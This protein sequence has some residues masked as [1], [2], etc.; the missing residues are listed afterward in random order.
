MNRFLA[1]IVV[2]VAVFAIGCGGDDESPGASA[3]VT[4]ADNAP[5]AGPP[6]ESGTPQ[7]EE[8]TPP[9][10]GV[11]TPQETPAAVTGLPSSVDLQRVFPDLSFE[12][13]TGLYQLP[14][15][16]WLATEQAGRVVLIDRAG[17]QRSVLQDL[18]DRVSTDGNEEGLLGLALAPDYI[19]SEVFY[20]YY[21][22]ANPRRSVISRFDPGGGETVLLE[23]GEPF[24]NH[25]GGQIVFGPDGYLYV[26]LG[27]GGSARDPQGNGQNL[28]TLLGSLLRI[29][30]SGGGAGYSVPPDNPFVGRAGARGEIWAYGLRNPWRFSF[31]AVT[32]DL[33]LGDVG[34]NTREEIDLIV[35]GGNYGWN[36]MEGF[37]CLGGGSNCDQ[38]GLLPP[39]IDYANGGGEC[40]VTGGFVYRGSAIAALQGAYVYT[41]YCSGKIWALRFDGSQVTEQ[42]QIGQADFRVSSFAQDN[43]GELYL[44]DHGDSGGV[45]RLVP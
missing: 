26:G 13:L 23:I 11:A 36:V 38:D 43:G 41:D 6:A 42:E 9:A 39:V 19:D 31:D 45:Y 14:S 24:S 12:R 25:N 17:L 28:G 1:G 30:V 20:V 35:K 37:D 7:A 2:L 32:G 29:D 4:P 18:T 5:T 3:S 10:D 22:S 40:S 33:W 21:S 15:G 16:A 27:D 34:Q 8:G 44:L